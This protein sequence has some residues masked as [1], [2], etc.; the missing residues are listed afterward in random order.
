MSS[1]FNELV[2]FMV[3]FLRV[4][5]VCVRACGE[6]LFWVGKCSGGVGDLWSTSSRSMASAKTRGAVGAPDS[7]TCCYL[8]TGSSR[9]A[10]TITMARQTSSF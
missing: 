4:V 8:T 10:I 6:E 7:F 1:L 3:P 5:V 9:H 2:S